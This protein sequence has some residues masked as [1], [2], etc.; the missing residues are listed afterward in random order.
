MRLA[1]CGCV[2]LVGVHGHLVQVEVH[3]GG[4]PGFVL[5]GLPDTALAEARDRVR[6]AVLCSGEA[7]PQQ[8]ITVNLSPAS[9]PKR[10]TH[11]DL[12]VAV[13]VLAADGRLRE[14]VI[15][16]LV[17]L[18]E[19]GLDGAVRPVRGVL[20]AVLAAHDAGMRRVVVPAA[21]AG[22]ARLVPGMQVL[23]ATSLA[24]VL[25]LLRG[26]VTVDH[27]SAAAAVDG[28]AAGG[29][30]GVGVAVDSRPATSADLP[31]AADSGAGPDLA[32][33]IG[34]GNARRAVEVAAAGHHHLLLTGPP[35]GGKT[36]LARRLPG[37][38]PDLRRREALE[39]TA[40]HSLAGILPEDRPLVTRPPFADPH[41][42]ATRAAIVGGGSRLVRPGAAAC[43]HRGVLLLDEAPEFGPHVLECLR[44]PL[45]H[46]EVVVDR[47]EFS[48]RFPARFL[49]VL[50][51]NP[52]PCG[53]HGGSTTVCEC[54]PDAVRRYTRRL[55]GPV[56]DRVDLTV[57]VK[58]PSLAE[59]RAG[60]ARSEPSA[61]VSVRVAEAR[62]R[63]ARRL[64]GTPWSVNGDVPGPTMRRHFAPHP[65]SMEPVERF[66]ATGVLS[67]RGADRVLRV[68]WTLADLAGRDRPGR[69][70]VLEAHGLR[71][72][73]AA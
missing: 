49:L 65:G 6:A 47:A 8:R 72:G 71:S 50:A 15:D 14:G 46:G 26:M 11:F 60:T 40:I 44:Q 57:W 43:A 51:S 45:E 73:S 64:A 34:Q 23:A 4:M 33:V 54:T 18:G 7:W 52:C 27:E 38:L 58:A 39:V 68:A 30:R 20:P 63:Q 41:H 1:T 53:H 36:M 28:A 70:E 59:M 12:S 10:G 16:G 24:Q 55:S 29:P 61:A 25:A 69:R 48:A 19:L 21:N 22:E 37:L 32:D 3:I 9:I 17:L 35:G 5:V 13:A 2:A 66:L 67:A 62:E 42:S 31:A 56:R